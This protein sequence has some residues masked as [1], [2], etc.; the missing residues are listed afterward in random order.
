MP[1]LS[2]TAYPRTKTAQLKFDKCKKGDVVWFVGGY[3]IAGDWQSFGRR[4]RVVSVQ[5]TGLKG[6]VF[7]KPDNDPTGTYCLSCLMTVADIQANL[8]K[9]ETPELRDAF[10]ARVQLQAGD[11]DVLKERAAIVKGNGLEALTK[12]EL[13]A[14][15][16]A[17][18][19]ELAFLK[20]TA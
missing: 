15:V 12:V 17:L 3:T 7:V 11:L 1:E 4:A 9:Q 6:G 16:K 19:A 18:E 13:I 2:M 10:L 14:R 8:S 5:A 20:E